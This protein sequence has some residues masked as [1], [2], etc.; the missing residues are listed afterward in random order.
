MMKRMDPVQ[1]GVCAPQGFAAGS[2]FAGV[3][4]DGKKDDVAIICS[5]V[6]AA[7]AAVYT[8]NLVKAACLH[9]T[10]EHLEDGMLQA[11]IV[12]SGNANVAARNGRLHAE[13]MA[14]AAAKKLNLAPDM[15][16]VA[17][18][19]VIGQELPAWK[20]VAAVENIEL[21]KEGSGKAAAA[22]MTTDTV[23][24]TTETSFQIGDVTCTMGGICKGSG[25]I[26]PN[27]GTMLCFVTCDAAI[28]PNMLEK[29]LQDVVRTTFN[30]ISVDGD[31][32]TND[33]CLILSNGMAK[34]ALID[35]EGEAYDIFKNAL[36]EVM[37]TLAIKI[38][39]DGEGASRLITVTVHDAETEEQAETLARSVASSS[40]LKAAMFGSDANWGRVMCAMGYSGAKFDPEIVDIAFASEKGSIEVCHQGREVL[41]DEEKASEI[42]KEDVVVIDVTLHEGDQSATCWGCDLTYDYVSING[43]Y[44]S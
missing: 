1:T 12:N 13:E 37:E 34:N 17:S 39:S 31:T 8:R 15:V 6:P 5:E 28:T 33:M 16:A 32:S 19:G 40:L 36:H 30:R 11:V 9:V 20:I 22:I 44:R 42:L 7:A 25:M 18:T 10:K 29:A 27:M 35:V 26:H 23:M 3:K 2:I 38:A 41:F 43:D 14:A 4:P 24:K 21:S